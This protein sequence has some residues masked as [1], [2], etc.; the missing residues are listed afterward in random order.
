MINEKTQSFCMAILLT[1]Q[2]CFT[3]SAAISVW[4]V[5]ITTE[6][7][8]PKEKYETGAKQTRT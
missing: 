8:S 2:N 3:F 6:I 7:K 1:K 4:H 5:V